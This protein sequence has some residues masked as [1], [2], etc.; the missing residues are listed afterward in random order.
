MNL[1]DYHRHPYSLNINGS[2]L[3]ISSPQVMGILNVTPDSFYCESRNYSAEEVAARCRQMV[4]EE[5]GMIDIGAYSS[6]PGAVPVTTREEMER[7]RMALPAVRE[8]SRGAILSV[9]TFRSDVAKMCVE[10][11]GVAIVNDI[12]GGEIDSRMMGTVARLGVPYVL[13]H[14][15]GTPQTMQAAPIYRSGVVVE[16]IA[17]LSERVARLR[18]AG[19]KDIIVD[20][21]FGF[22]KT[23]E[24]N[25][26]LLSGLDCLSELG[27]PVLAGMS[28]KSMIYNCLGTTPQ[29]A[30]NGTTAANVIALAKGCS[31][32]R[33]HDVVQAVEAVK[34]YNMMLK[35]GASIGTNG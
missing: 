11:Y 25:Y 22:G 27:L 7:L 14:M 3:E 10:E 34:V 18:D 5:A 23:L 21:G 9:D 31:I 13:M 2:L 16:V 8:W 12:S 35:A 28:R 17:Y 29:G 26:A 30:L 4:A 15:Q 20:P 6:R 32:L 24:Q 33:V 19:V 1:F